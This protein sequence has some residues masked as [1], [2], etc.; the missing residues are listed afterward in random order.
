MFVYEKSYPNSELFIRGDQ[1]FPLHSMPDRRQRSG[2]EYILR[3]AYIKE[4]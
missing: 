4:P 1:R 3:K 2:Y